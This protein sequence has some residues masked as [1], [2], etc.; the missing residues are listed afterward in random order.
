MNVHEIPLWLNKHSR[1]FPRCNGQ[2][3]NYRRTADFCCCYI[4]DILIYCDTVEEHEQHV[5]LV[6]QTLYKY[7]LRAHPDKSIFMAPVM[8]FLGFNING[9]GITPMEA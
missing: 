3:N 9:I 8:E 5:K 6:L 1:P 2:Y 4:D 7:N